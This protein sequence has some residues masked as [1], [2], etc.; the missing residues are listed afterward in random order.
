MADQNRKQNRDQSTQQHQGNLG[1]RD[2]SLQPGNENRGLGQT[3][4]ERA[5][6]EPASVADDR[7]L[8]DDRSE[9]GIGDDRD[10]DELGNRIDSDLDRDERDEEDLDDV[11]RMDR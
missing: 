5:K 4:R 10:S 3:E 1:Q 6:R 9:R 2:D 8:G 7:G 11:T